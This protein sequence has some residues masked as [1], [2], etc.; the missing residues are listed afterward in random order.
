MKKRIVGL[1]LVFLLIFSPITV[2]ADAVVG[3]TIVV[4]GADLTAEQRSQM[5]QQF[6]APSNAQ[7]V[8]VTNAEEHRY[9]DGVIPV[10]QI[11]SIA[12]LRLVLHILP[13]TPG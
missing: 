7:I 1:L 3:D 8:E 10:A 4:L 11:G 5:L 12:Y 13:R 2:F 9:L 6:N